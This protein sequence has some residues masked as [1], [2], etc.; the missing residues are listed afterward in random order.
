MAPMD[1]MARLAALLAPPKMPLVR[2]HGVF[3]S[4]SSWRK[5]VTPKPRAPKPSP[6]AASPAAASPAAASPAAASPAAAS[7]AAASPTEAFPVVQ[8]EPTRISVAHW[9]RLDEG[10][11]LAKSRYI[12]W[13]V[14]MKRT[15]GFSVLR[16]PRCSRRMQVH[17]TVTQPHVVRKI[18]EHLGVRADPLPRAPARDPEWDQVDLPF[19]EAA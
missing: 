7:P 1:F 17:A 12:D 8:V 5:L 15:F 18:L 3:A 9:G 6:A 2:Y 19:D 11:L 14:L 10:E 16:C 13:A 4:R